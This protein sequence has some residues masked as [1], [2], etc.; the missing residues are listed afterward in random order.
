M[1]NRD[2]REHAVVLGLAVTGPPQGPDGERPDR[3]FQ[4]FRLADGLIIDIRGYPT[5]EEALSVADTPVSSA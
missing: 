1:G 4:M 3:V 2:L 5:R